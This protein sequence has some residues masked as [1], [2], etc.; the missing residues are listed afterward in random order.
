M[1][2]QLIFRVFREEQRSFIAAFSILFSLLIIAA[3]GIYL[4]EHD[5]QP[6][7]FGSILEAMWWAMATLTTVGYGD[8]TP[9]THGGK[10]FGGLVTIV[11]MGMV[12]LPA[13]ILASGFN[14]QMQRRR[15]K[16]NVLLKQILQDGLVTEQEWSDLEALRTQ[17]GL[18]KE[19][20]ELLIALSEARKDQQPKC[21]HCGGLLHPL[22]REED[23]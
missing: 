19:E 1:A 20:A 8:V 16:F 22:R 4:I 12:A 6:D 10:F 15:Q 14:A 2:I 5:V 21:P 23:G 3:S 11:S 17:L 9:I 7:E 13:G 18:D